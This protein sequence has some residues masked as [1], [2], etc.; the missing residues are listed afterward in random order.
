MTVGVA[1]LQYVSLQAITAKIEV[2][3]INITKSIVQNVT[4][5]YLIFRTEPSKG[6]FF[7]TF[8]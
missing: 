1:S 8:F 2:K 4:N 5:F 6:E 7:F 3:E